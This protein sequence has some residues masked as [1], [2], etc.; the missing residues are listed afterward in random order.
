MHLLRE[1]VTLP[2]NNQ[3]Y[4]GGALM[5]YMGIDHHKQYSYITLLRGVSFCACGKSLT[6]LLNFHPLTSWNELITGKKIRFH[7]EFLLDTLW[8]GRPFSHEG[9]PQSRYFST[10]SII[11]GRKYP[12]SQTSVHTLPKTSQNNGTTLGTF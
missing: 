5:N 7:Q 4:L 1:F 9:L 3:F 12:Y 6:I 11:T 8:R 10:T 2:D